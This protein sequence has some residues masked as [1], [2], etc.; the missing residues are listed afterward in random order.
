MT[1]QTAIQERAAQQAELQQQ[2]EPTINLPMLMQPEEANMIIQENLEGMGDM[3]FDKINMPS[4]GG[5]AFTVVDESG[6]ETPLTDLKGVILHKKPFR[7]W[8][9]KAF[10]EKSEEDTGRPDCFSEDN[11]HGSGCEEAGIPE[12]QLCKTCPKNQWGSDRHGGKGKDCAEK[13]RLHILME[14]NA[15]PKFIDLPPTSI[16]NFK[17]Y[18]KRLANKLNPFYGVVTTTGLAVDKNT[19][20]IKY[21]KATFAKSASLS[22][23]ERMAIR[24]YIST[25]LPIMERI[26]P[27]S[28]APNEADIIEASS[29]AAGSGEQ[30]Y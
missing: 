17:D 8:Y 7:A 2:T 16:G 20:G 19:G 23:E 13:I 12:G 24:Q 15:F 30:P 27:E 11:I 4:G 22:K 1:E 21:S 14:E 10:D 6:K 3:K 25:L 9:I 5:I 28:I 26:S 18:V 29:D